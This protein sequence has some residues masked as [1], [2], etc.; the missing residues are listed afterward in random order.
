[1]IDLCNYSK[2]HDMYKLMIVVNKLDITCTF[3]DNDDGG[4][5]VIAISAHP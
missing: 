4:D 5:G 1:M 3:P 2:N